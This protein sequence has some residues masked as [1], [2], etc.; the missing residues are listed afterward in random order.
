[1][2]VSALLYVFSVNQQ[3]SRISMLVTGGVNVQFRNAGTGFM[4][5]GV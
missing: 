3:L 4:Y 2:K 1:M 5:V